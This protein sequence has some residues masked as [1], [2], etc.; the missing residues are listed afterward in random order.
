M[1]VVRVMLSRMSLVTGGVTIWPLRIM[2]N[3]APVPSATRPCWFRKI[4]GVV[5]VG[6]GLERGEAAVLVVRRRT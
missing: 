2:K 1:S 6:L 3:V 4:G 5:A